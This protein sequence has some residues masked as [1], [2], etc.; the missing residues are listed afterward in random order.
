MRAGLYC[1]IYLYILL[2][3]Y[4]LRCLFSKLQVVFLGTP[5]TYLPYRRSGKG[6]V[7]LRN[8]VALPKGIAKETLKYYRAI[9]QNAIDEGIDKGVQEIRR[10]MIDKVLK[11]LG[12]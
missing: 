5:K 9:A 4:L 11:A 10:D 2:S 6:M 1:L 8:L 7:G 12:N 3:K